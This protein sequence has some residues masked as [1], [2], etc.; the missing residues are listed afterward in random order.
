MVR[1]V[2]ASNHTTKHTLDHLPAR[3]QT[4]RRP[5]ADAISAFTEEVMII[6]FGSYA[7]ATTWRTTWAAL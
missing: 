1:V 3:T 5:A 2:T 4:R 6:L 7:A